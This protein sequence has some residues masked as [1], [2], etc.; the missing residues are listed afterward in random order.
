MATIRPFRAWRFSKKIEP[1]EALISP[2]IDH[3]ESLS[4]NNLYNNPHNSIHLSRPVK[5]NAGKNIADL[6]HKW[7]EEK[8]IIQDPLPAIYVYYQYYKLPGSEAVHCQKGFICNV[9]LT[10]DEDAY[11]VLKHEAVI[12]SS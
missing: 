7:K 1:I 9:D 3:S 5:N 4:I 10:K 8:I 11:H 2:L 12:P 6:V